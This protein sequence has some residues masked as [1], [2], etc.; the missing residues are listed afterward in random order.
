MTTSAL[1]LGACGFG[2]GGDDNAEGAGLNPGDYTVATNEGVSDSVVVNGTIE[3][4]RSV[5]ISTAVQ[6]EVEKVAVKAGDRVQPQQFLASMNSEQL[7]R[8]LEVQQKQQANAQADAQAQVDQARAA[9]NAH[10]ESV[11]NG[12]NEAIRAAQA[13]VNQAQAAYDAAVA[14]NGGARMINRGIA[15]V[16]RA[17]GGISSDLGIRT[18]PPAQP[19]APK[20]PE[21]PAAPAMPGQPGTP[22]TPGQL[23]TPGELSPE[24]LA[25][26]TG[27]S[28]AGGAGGGAAVGPGMSVEEA[29]A[30]LQDAKAALAAAQSAAAQEGNQLQAQLD[31]AVRQAET[32]ELGDGDGTLEYQVREST[33]YAPMAGL[34]TSVDVREGDIPQGKLLTI[35]DDSRLVIRTDVRESDVPNIKEGD[36]VEFTTAATGKKT[37]KGRVTRIAPASDSVAS[38]NQNPMQGMPQQQGNNKSNEVTFP[39][40][41]EVTG[42]KEGLLLGGSARAEI[43]T[44]EAKDALNV[45]LDAV[46]GEDNDQKVLVLAT[47]GD[48]A[49][50]GTVEE[51]SVKTGAS[52]DVDV[53]VTG[54]ELKPGDIVINWPEEYED[55]VG[56]NVEITDPN[57]NPDQVRQAR[58]KKERTTATVTVTSTRRAAEGQQ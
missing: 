48:D 31:S 19:A 40:E 38:G 10:Q 51:R 42:D 43:I 3:P 35:A 14:A 16:E 46:Y 26:L 17:A 20:A 8:Q 24:Q 13:Q 49:A 30:A 33:I 9:L 15:A 44:A 56:E 41:I 37:F 5:N 52:N 12:T 55:R 53:A 28:G 32:A 29:S 34:V 11:N 45:P 4:I 54:G 39:V 25:Q 18:A 2:G 58:E 7:E 1:F 50:S 22:G 27:E 47:D 23:G 57:F 21:A 6:S 36:R